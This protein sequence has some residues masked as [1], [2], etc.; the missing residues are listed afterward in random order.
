MYSFQLMH[1]TP[2][3]VCCPYTPKPTE[4]WGHDVKA[5]AADTGGMEGST[6]HIHR[7]SRP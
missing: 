3:R 6:P 5:A 4:H 2:Q 1:T 7:D